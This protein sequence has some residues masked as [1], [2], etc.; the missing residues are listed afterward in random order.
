MALEQAIALALATPAQ[1]P[2]PSEVEAT[3]AVETMAAALTRRERE[4]ALLIARGQ[5]DRQIAN[6]LGVT[7]DTVGG[8]AKHLYR[9]LG[10]RTRA[11]VAVWAV[12]RAELLSPK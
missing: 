7:E 12:A 8:H 1:G 6:A 3:P 4:V 10:V 2:A 9:K 11:E 5:T